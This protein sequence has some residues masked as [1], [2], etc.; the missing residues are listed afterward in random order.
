VRT[1]WLHLRTSPV[2]WTVPVLIAVDVAVL[3]LRTR[4]WIGIWPETG[5]AAQVPAYLL[6]PLTA[7]AAAWAASA[8]VR[9]GTVEQCAAARVPHRVSEAYRLGATVILLLTP[10]LVGQLVAA[11]PTARTFPPGLGLWFGYVMLGLFVTLLTVALGWFVGMFFTSV[12]ATMTAA[13]GCLLLIGLLDRGPEPIVVT[14]SPEVMVGATGVVLRLVLVIALLAGLVGVRGT[15]RGSILPAATALVLVVAMATTGVIVDR[16]PPGD[17]V[18]CVRGA[19]ALCVWP[20]HRKYLAM[21]R[22]FESR[23]AALPAEFVVP[24]TV[25]EYGLVPTGVS[26]PGDHEVVVDTAD[27]TPTFVLTEGS[28]WSAANDLSNAIAETTFHFQAPTTCHWDTRTDA[29][30]SR[31]NAVGAWLQSYLVGG[32]TPDY[33]TDAPTSMQ[34]AW[35]AGRAVA[36]D[37]TLTQ[38]FAWAGKE[39]TDLRGRYCGT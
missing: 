36:A 24:H 5:A 3:F 35:A 13:L 22:G 12:F 21:L 30:Q 20:E 10:Y 38:Q 14:G 34:Q 28:A 15:G 26:G 25:D 19:T 11:A 1:L 9:H 8:P 27:P 16:N 33:R 17:G 39:V 23:I 18:L 31:L 37:D 4:Y 7:G 32:G 29:D 6:G 2:R